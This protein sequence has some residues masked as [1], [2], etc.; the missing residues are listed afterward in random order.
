M[1]PGWRRP[2]VLPM[3]CQR[4]NFSYIQMTTSDFPHS[5]LSRNYLI[6]YIV[7]YRL[8]WFI[9][10]QIFCISNNTNEILVNIVITLLIIISRFFWI[11][12]HINQSKFET[13]FAS[14]ASLSLQPRR[15]SAKPITGRD[16][17]IFI[18]LQ[19]HY[20]S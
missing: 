10:V 12:F 18:G 11:C 1:T 19:Q 20:I 3:A 7:T 16:K 8:V 9:I 5:S 4:L 17:C 6:I 14:C 2:V 13:L 15:N